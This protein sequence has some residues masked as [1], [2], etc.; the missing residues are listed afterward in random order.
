MDSVQTSQTWPCEAK[1][2]GKTL[3]I[4]EANQ[5]AQQ[6]PRARG[7]H[8]FTTLSTRIISAFPLQQRPV[9]LHLAEVHRPQ[10][11]WVQTT[12]IYPQ[13]TSPGVMV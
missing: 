5:S 3:N 13:N 2:E 7:I 1:D 10:A 9:I 8:F 11:H 4:P 12:G 6:G